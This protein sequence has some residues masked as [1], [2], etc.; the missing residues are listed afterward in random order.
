MKKLKLLSLAV[1]TALLASTNSLPALAS[2]SSEVLQP[3]TFTIYSYDC[4]TGEE[5]Y[6]EL[7]TSF[8]TEQL[9]KGITNI[10]TASF[11]GTANDESIG[12]SPQDVIGGTDSRYRIYDTTQSLYR[13]VCFLN[14]EFAGGSSATGTG[15]LVGPDIVLTAA[16]MVNDLDYGNASSISVTPAKNGNTEP[17]Y[18]TFKGTTIYLP[19][20]WNGS[21]Y[22]AYDWA[23]IRLK[24]LNGTSTT[25]GNK[26]GYFDLKYLSGDSLNT[27]SVFVTGYA[28]D[29]SE[30]TMW[31]S[32]GSIT[33]TETNLIY[34]DCDT[35][36]GDSGAPVTNS[37]NKV[38]GIHIGV[39]GASNRG[40]RVT[41]EVVSTVDS[42]K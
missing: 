6:I 8:V 15:F 1:C 9:N 14:V 31:R 3:E 24:N 20:K 32:G 35:G 34:Y 22:P 18:E 39:S 27:I 37:A 40:V 25:I 12:I 13:P 4:E 7:D 21:R 36:K 23:V 33:Y 2:T 26:I 5:E 11:E 38:I 19:D 10:S 16:H 41:Q 30:G 17:P 29:K 28:G 42:L